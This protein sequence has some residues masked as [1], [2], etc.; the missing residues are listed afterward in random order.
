[1]HVRA[2]CWVR[3]DS[4]ALF[5]LAEEANVKSNIVNDKAQHVASIGLK[6]PFCLGQSSRSVLVDGRKKTTTQGPSVWGVV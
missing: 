3:L 1:M 2:C 6:L 5:S 4:V